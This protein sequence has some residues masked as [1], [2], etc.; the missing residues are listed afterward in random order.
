MPRPINQRDEFAQFYVAAMFADEG[1]T[2]HFPVPDRGFDFIATKKNQRGMV[3]RPVQVKGKYPESTIRIIKAF[4]F[5]GKLSAPHSTMV[6][7][8]PLFNSNERSES[9]ALVAFMPW[10][11]IRPYSR[12]PHCSRPGQHIRGKVKEKEEYKPFFG[13]TGLQKFENPDYN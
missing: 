1:W 9:P 4:G 10:S 12:W 3:I 6:L 8:I 5:I 11:E 13:R 2:L 7:A